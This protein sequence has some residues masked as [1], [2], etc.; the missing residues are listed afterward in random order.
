MTTSL[1]CDCCDH[2]LQHLVRQVIARYEAPIPPPTTGAIV[3]E[4]RDGLA[5]WED[6][7]NPPRPSRHD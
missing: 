1:R 7:Q 4:L 5:D 6:E 2:P 3:R